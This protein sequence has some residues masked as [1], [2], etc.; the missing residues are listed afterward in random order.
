MYSPQQS[1]F[2]VLFLFLWD[3]VSLCS[4]GCPGTHCVDQA[5]LELR[6]LPASA[7]QVLG[8]KACATTAR[9]FTAFLPTAYHRMEDV[10]SVS[11]SVSTRPNF[12]GP[13]SACKGRIQ[14][15]REEEL[16]HL[17]V[18]AQEPWAWGASTKD[19]VFALPVPSQAC[20]SSGLPIS[21]RHT[22]GLQASMLFGGHRTSRKP[23]SRKV[24][25]QLHTMLCVTEP[26]CHGN[27]VQTLP[28]NEGPTFM[29]NSKP[30]KAHLPL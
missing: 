3:R 15:V 4:P 20:V 11:K 16:V 27:S 2:V 18:T 19:S 25:S 22:L 23:P 1:F 9:Q 12:G 30:Q 29:H 6:N 13:L 28:E 14:R 8:L 7:S 26:F 17:P 21:S 5:G 24:R 10:L